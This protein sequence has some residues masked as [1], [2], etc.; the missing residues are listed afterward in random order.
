MKTPRFVL[1]AACGLALL[2]GC[3]SPTTTAMRMQE[4]NS[5]IQSLPEEQQKKIAGGVVEVGYTADMVYVALGR[6]SRV[7]VTTDGRVGIWTYDHYLPSEAVS[8][9]PF[10][11]VR[12]YPKGMPAFRGGSSAPSAHDSGSR[13]DVNRGP[14]EA[15]PLAEADAGPVTLEIL[16]QKGRVYRMEVTDGST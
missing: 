5:V 12:A 16:F 1:G 10:Y 15:R 13:G 6:P 3:H 9:K 7:S 8:S 2:A 11:T 14:R 4:K